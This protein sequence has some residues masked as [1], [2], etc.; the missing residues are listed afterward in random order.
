MCL[1]SIQAQI[2]IMQEESTHYQSLGNDAQYFE[3][4]PN[5]AIRT[6]KS[7]SNCNLN[8]IVYGWHPY[9][10]GTNYQNYD[11]EL[12]THMSFFSYEVNPSTGNANTTNGW[13]TSQAVNAALASG[14]TKV[15]LCVTLFSDFNTFFG[16][17]TAPQTLISN[18]ISLV[19][20][21]GAQGVNI[22]FEGMSATHKTSFANFMVSL[23]N[24]MHTAIPGSEVSTVLYAVEWSDVFD[25]TIMNQ[26]VDHYIVM[27]YDYYWSGSSN[28]G[29]NDPLYHFG[30]TYNYTLSRSTSYYLHKGAPL[31]K[32][33]MGLPY[34]GREW[35]TSS[36]TLGASTTGSGTSRTYTVVKTN[37]S[38]NF[39]AANR[40]QETDSYTDVFVFNS[41]G[42]RQCYITLEDNFRKRLEHVNQSGIAGIGIWALGY[43]NG[44]S[45]L[46]DAIEDYMTDCYETPCPATIHDFG[47]PKNYYNNEN[48]TW[49]IAPE[50]ATSITLT[51][52][53]FDVETNYDYLYIYDG[54][55]IA[56]PQ[57]AGSPFSGNVVPPVI[58]SSGGALTFRFTS[59]NATTRPGFVASYTCA[60]DVTAPTSSLVVPTGWKTQD[61]SVSIVD[62]DETGGS[63]VDKRFYQVLD[64]DGADWRANAANGF[65]S[66]NFDQSALH[67]DWTAVVGNWSLNNGYLYQADESN[68]NTNAYAALNQNN[69]TQWMHNFAMRISGA[70]SSRRAGYHFMCD[71]GSLPNR[72]NSYFVW[73]RADNNKIQL[74]K[75]VN[76]VFSLQADVSYTINANQ[77]YNVDVVYD[78]TTGVIEVW[79][80]NSFAASWT[81]NAPLT[82][83][84]AISFRSGDCVLEANNLKVYHNHQGNPVV[85]VGSPTGDIRYQNS[86]PNIPSGRIKSLSID[87]ARNI[88]AIAF[89]D[90]NVDWTPPTGLT[91]VNDGLSGDVDVFNIPTEV[92][93]NWNVAMDPHSGVTAYEYAVGT[94]ALG[95]DI[96][97]WTSNGLNTSFTAAGLSLNF[98]TIYY[99][100]V[101]ALNGAGLYSA[102][103][104]SDGQLLE[105]PNQPPVA[106]FQTNS[107]II[108]QND[109]IQLIN[110]ST[111]ATDFVWSSVTGNISQPNAV[112]PYITVTQA[113]THSITLLVSGPGGNDQITQDITVVFHDNPVAQFTADHL[114]VTLP[115]A[116]VGFTNNSQ[117]STAYF[118]DF[119]NGIT[120]TDEHPWVQYDA[121]GIYTVMLV[122]QNNQCE[123]D[124]TF[125][126]I[127]VQEFDASGIE[128]LDAFQLVVYPVPLSD[129]LVISGIPLEGEWIVTLTDVSGRLIYQSLPIKGS[130][131]VVINDLG[132]LSKGIYFVQ[133]MNNHYEIRQMI[134]L[135]K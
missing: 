103:I 111:S 33:V 99:V 90:V 15:T 114:T 119:G 11:W 62:Q 29:P 58:T 109:S 34:Y 26:A 126:E 129:L 55:T 48:Y 80:D 69:H 110:T 88:S 113:G 68:T 1:S 60:S 40:Q 20:S 83:G 112:N 95:T 56:S 5:A 84:H 7:R 65:F 64:F 21:R 39:S 120:S 123:N 9:W 25:F 128:D 67:T 17:S 122:A 85:T 16:S 10:G 125:L 32:L 108:C 82:V 36:T 101:R 81:D 12:L 72:G 45:E 116:V 96:I 35:P 13:A 75:V 22:D 91:V 94:T 27:G 43:D 8:K 79:L 70:G 73:F 49:T 77:W 93:G 102:P 4:I 74:Y 6:P 89:E 104:S 118:W 52:S 28:A 57:V 47:G 134:K 121:A 98:G 92:S 14:N 86:Q 131:Q 53:S 41:G 100:S 23:A 50:G 127:T 105:E 106:G 54:P 44:Y 115:N 3:A 132:Y 38:G 42:T 30:A 130:E 117:S 51:F 19:Q 66:D 59:D 63:G 76:D 124:T 87:G 24:Q 61:F 31:N 71:D 2:S 37:A 46:W 78:K 107:Y 133:L 135:S 18:L 97:N